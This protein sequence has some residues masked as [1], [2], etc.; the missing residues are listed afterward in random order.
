MSGP[1]L[2][3]IRRPREMERC[4]ESS[5]H[6]HIKRTACPGCNVL[7]SKTNA[8]SMFTPLTNTWQRLRRPAMDAALATAIP[9]A[10]MLGGAVSAL[11]ETLDGKVVGI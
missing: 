8:V 5:K 10:L 4:F 3:E 9:L 6:Q 7:A 11:A 2:W 1:W